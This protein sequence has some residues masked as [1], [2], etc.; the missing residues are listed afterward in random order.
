MSNIHGY[1]L[2]AHEGMTFDLRSLKTKLP[3]SL[4]RFS[5]LEKKPSF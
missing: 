3:F 5:F 2:R 1:R 4:L